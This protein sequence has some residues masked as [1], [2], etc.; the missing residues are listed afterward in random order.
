MYIAT[1]VPIEEAPPHV[2]IEDATIEHLEEGNQRTYLRQQQMPIYEVYMSCKILSSGGS[3]E[4][5]AHLS[6]IEQL[7]KEAAENDPTKVILALSAYYITFSFL[8]AK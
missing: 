7:R 4:Y 6:Y 1:K 3:M 5:A 8:I 2:A